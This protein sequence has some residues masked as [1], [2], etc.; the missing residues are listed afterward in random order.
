M[1]I[2]EFQNTIQFDVMGTIKKGYNCI[3]AYCSR[4]N[5]NITAIKPYEN[6]ICP[7]CRSEASPLAGEKEFSQSVSYFILP[8]HLTARSDNDNPSRLRVIPAYKELERTF[9][10]SYAKYAKNRLLF[11]SGNGATAER[12][13]H[14]KKAKVQVPCNDSCSYRKDGTC[15]PSATLYVVLPDYDMFS[16][17]KITT[18]S[19]TSIRNIYSTLNK[20][21][22]SQGRIAR[23]ICEIRIIEKRRRSD[24]KVY[25]VLQ[26]VP[27]MVSLDEMAS[28][29]QE[30]FCMI[31]HQKT[32]TADPA[33]DGST[34]YNDDTQERLA[35]G[36]TMVREKIEHYVKGPYVMRALEIYACNKYGKHHFDDLTR[37]DL[38]SLWH[39]IDEKS[40]MVD[41]IWML[42]KKLRHG[43]G[44]ELF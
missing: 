25:R 41:E 32:D 7:E 14:H 34:D 13:D 11:C 20:L 19:E 5:R 28:L 10:S 17:Y 9:P 3:K 18:R 37:E 23:T 36:R 42:S 39:E 33:E 40:K 44:E 38:L 2:E 4:C 21:R 15:K 43:V 12:Y 31:D 29:Q 6:F 26:L 24:N 8:E 30:H 1:I 35:K 16:A 27:P 22:D